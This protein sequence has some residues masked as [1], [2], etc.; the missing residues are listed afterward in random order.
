[1]GSSRTDITD[2]VRATAYRAQADAA[3]RAATGGSAPGHLPG[4][5]IAAY[6]VRL[7]TGL[8]PFSQTYK[9]VADRSLAQMYRAGALRNAEETIY[10]EAA[11]HAR[12]PV[13]ALREV[14]DPPDRSGRTIVRF[15]GNPEDCWAP[16]KQT[17]R[18]VARFN[19]VKGG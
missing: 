3:Y 15:F 4:E 19:V 13:G 11:E 12:R 17:P 9:S 18:M 16:F 1:M 14:P 5:S 7:A 6:R 10:R 2:E 8:K